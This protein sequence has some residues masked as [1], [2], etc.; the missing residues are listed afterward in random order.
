MIIMIRFGTI[1]TSKIV[2]DFIEASLK[3]NQLKVTCCYSRDKT[4]ARN[5]INK[6]SIYAVATDKF[7]ILIDEA[8]AIYIASPNGLHYEQAKYFLSQQKHVLLEKPLTLDFKQAEELFEIAIKNGVVLMEAYKT[9]HLPQFKHLLDFT[10]SYQPFMIN[11]NLNKVTSRIKNLKNRIIDNIFDYELGRG[12]TY[13]LLIYPVEL[14]VALFGKVE[15][16]KAFG[17]KLENKSGLTDCVIIKHQSGVIS[18]ITCSK[19]TNGIIENEI[20]SDGLTMTF[21]D[22]I[23]LKS[24]SIHKHNDPNINE[25][26]YEVL[27]NNLVYEMLVFTKMIETNDYALRDYLMNISLEALKTLNIIEKEQ[28]Q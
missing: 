9:I 8:D 19:V 4:K 27:E 13:D 3:S 25:L 15:S 16:V 2:N 26:N 7:D 17:Q 22:L 5:L 20:L 14:S 28:N 11:L 12:S 24:I 23:N 1:G 18:N 10:N 21:K 6:F